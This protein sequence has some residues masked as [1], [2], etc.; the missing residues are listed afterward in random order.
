MVGLRHGVDLHPSPGLVDPLSDGASDLGR[1][2]PHRLVDDERPR[3]RLPLRPAHVL[4]DDLHRI[5]APDEPVA[6]RDGLDLE[7][8]PHD[9]LHLAH[10][11]LAEG[12]EDVAEV[13]A[14]LVPQ[15]GLI[16]LVCE[17][18][19]RGQVLAEGVVGQQQLVF[20]N[21]GKHAVGPVQ[22]RRLEEG[23]CLVPQRDRVTAADDLTLPAVREVLAERLLTPFAVDECGIW[24][25]GKYG[26]ERC[27]MVQL[28]VVGNQVVDL[29][30][31]DNLRDLA[32]HLALEP[33]HD[34]IDQGDAVI[35]DQVGVVRSAS[36][37]VVR[38]AVEVAH[39]PIHGSNPVH[40]FRDLCAHLVPPHAD[41]AAGQAARR[42][43]H[44]G[45]GQDGH[46]GRHCPESGPVY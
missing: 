20:G 15:H 43:Q 41:T 21:V 2:A 24:R 29:R 14:H 4:A 45:R 33:R 19:R 25:A 11:E 35:D 13:F 39:F 40:V 12:H 8:Q 37:R 5:L 3:L 42:L 34:R 7:P 26:R 6:G 32:E 30:G 31:V 38:V 22:H 10:D 46:S 44:A 28:G 16:D 1:A 36:M 23:Q 18:L 27:R 9:L 17:A